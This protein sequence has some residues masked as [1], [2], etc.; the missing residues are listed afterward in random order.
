MILFFT[1]SHC[2]QSKGFLTPLAP[3]L[4]SVLIGRFNLNNPNEPGAKVSSAQQ[5]ILHPDWNIEDDKYDADI[6]IVVLTET[7]QYSD[8]IQ[9]IC[10]PSATNQDPIGLGFVVGW[11]KSSNEAEYDE[12]PNQLEMPA[13]NASYC[14]TRFPKL[15]EYSSH[16]VFCAGFENEERGTCTGDSGGGFFMKDSKQFYWSVQGIVS[17][18]LINDKFDC[19]VNTFALYTNVALFRDWIIQETGES[20]VINW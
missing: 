10:L 11:G 16:R 18:S 17:S 9:P 5:I 20:A 1:A 13:V 15:A 2:F 19:D 14:F 8:Q 6:A 7:V 12:T 3:E 4:L